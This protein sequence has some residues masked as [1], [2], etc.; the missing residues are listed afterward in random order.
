MDY[1][2]KRWEKKREIILQ[3]DGYWCKDCSRYGRHQE[4][5]TVHHIFPVEFFP[6]LAF[7]NW[8]LISLCGGCH[9][10]MHDRESHR[11]T[12]KGWELLQRTARKNGKTIKPEWQKGLKA[13]EKK[14]A[15]NPWSGTRY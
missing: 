10:E 12:D 1:K 15:R 6:E 9:N 4:A 8:N 7:E 14:R 2:G 11:L 13:A 3:R 5:S